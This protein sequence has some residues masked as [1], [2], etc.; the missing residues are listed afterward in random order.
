[1][2]PWLAIAFNG[3]GLHYIGSEIDCSISTSASNQREN[4]RI[5]YLDDELGLA[6]GKAQNLRSN[7]MV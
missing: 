6:A 5:R 7:T 2:W 4:L 3:V 1:M